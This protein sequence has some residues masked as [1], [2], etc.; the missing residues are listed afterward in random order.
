M[1]TVGL[2][3]HYTEIKDLKFVDGSCGPF[4]VTLC[5][6]KINIIIISIKKKLIIIQL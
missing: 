3:L 2:F 6:K 5:S 4:V 1:S